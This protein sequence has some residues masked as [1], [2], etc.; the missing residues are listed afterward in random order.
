[1]KCLLVVIF[2]AAPAFSAP[3]AVAPPDDVWTPRNGWTVDTAHQHALDMIAAHD[4][5]YEQQFKAQQDAIALALA[6]QKEAVAA[7][8]MAQEKATA[9]SIAS[10]QQAVAKA[11]AASDKRFESVNEFRGQMNDQSKTFMPRGEVITSI[12]AM[13]DRIAGLSTRL[14]KAE[15]QSQGQAATWTVM[16]VVAGLLIGIVGAYLS[17]R[18]NVS[19]SGQITQKR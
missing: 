2:L 5:R 13:N 7:A 15:G 14:D 9:A 16:G 4:A 10:A 19:V 12:A 18:R 1:M 6:A 11:E 8:L 17:V 3:P